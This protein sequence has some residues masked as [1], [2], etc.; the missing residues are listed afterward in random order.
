M[1]AINVNSISTGLGL[2]INRSMISNVMPDQRCTGDISVISVTLVKIKGHMTLVRY[3]GL[4]TSITLSH[5]AFDV[6]LHI[7]STAT[8]GQV[9]AEVS[10]KAKN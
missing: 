5:I 4:D 10:I 9:Q 1:P 3:C 7:L 2:S 8:N 6:Y